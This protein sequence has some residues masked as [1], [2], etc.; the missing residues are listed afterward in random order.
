MVESADSSA[1]NDSF[2]RGTE[3]R[4]LC[5]ISS[6]QR[7]RFNTRKGNR[8]HWELRAM[9]WMPHGG[10]MGGRGGPVAVR[11]QKGTTVATVVEREI[12]RGCIREHLGWMD[13]L[14]CPTLPI[15]SE[16]QWRN[17]SRSSSTDAIPI[18]AFVAIPAGADRTP[19]PLR[20]GL[21]STAAFPPCAIAHRHRLRASGH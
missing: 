16:R 8:R 3:S 14:R 15:R 11:C 20:S 1:Q 5:A 12:S 9:P 18:T 2:R 4:A 7:V 10:P 13:P 17:S 6:P 21:H 19:I